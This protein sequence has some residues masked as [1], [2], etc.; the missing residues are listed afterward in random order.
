[1]LLGEATSID[2]EPLPDSPDLIPEH[3]TE[4]LSFALSISD[5]KQTRTV[6]A[7]LRKIFSFTQLPSSTATEPTPALPTGP[8]ALS[9]EF[10]GHVG[11][12][13]REI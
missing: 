9:S 6:V 5:Y 11:N 7:A 1:M 3:I 10:L 8:D 12:A 2:L 4:F 13:N